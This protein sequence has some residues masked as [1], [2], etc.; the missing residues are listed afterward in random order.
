MI[1]R[2][3]R[4]GTLV[5]TGIMFTACGKSETPATD[6][7]STMAPATPS[8]SPGTTMDTGM[9]MDTSMRRDSLRDTT[10]RD[11]TRRDTTP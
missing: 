8:T 10:R 11:T 2:T 6:T 9:R 3:L 5:I 7:T 4:F 1:N